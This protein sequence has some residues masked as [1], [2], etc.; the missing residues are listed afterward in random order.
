MMILNEREQQELLRLIQYE[1]F[2]N[3]FRWKKHDL[4]F[5]GNLIPYT[6]FDNEIAKIRSLD[7]NFHYGQIPPPKI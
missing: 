4:N 3:I 1:Q 6:E 2:Y 7:H 5:K